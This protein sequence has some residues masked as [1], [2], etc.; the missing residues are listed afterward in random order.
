MNW[1]ALVRAAQTDSTVGVTTT[2]PMVT[3]VLVRD[4]LD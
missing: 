1:R 3:G 2:K 4:S